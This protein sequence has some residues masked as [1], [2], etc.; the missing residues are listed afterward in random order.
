[1]AI[2]VNRVLHHTSAPRAPWDAHELPTIPLRG[3]ALI[4]IEF[5]T[6]HPLG[7]CVITSPVPHI[8]LLAFLFPSTQ[9]HV[10]ETP[11]HDAGSA[12]NV[13]RVA[14]PFSPGDAPADPFALLFTSETDE[15]QLIT[16]IRTNPAA[17]LFSFNSLPSHHLQGSLLLP[18]HAPLGSTALFLHYDAWAQGH[19][20]GATPT[21][22]ATHVC[23]YAPLTLGEELTFFHL[24][25][26]ATGWYDKAAETFILS[27]ALRR[28]TDAEGAYSDDTVIATV[29]EFLQLML[30]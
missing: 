22:A 24:E 17:A 19:E 25:T 12:H 3:R 23:T 8:G 1:M 13:R 20:P 21:P 2:P 10:Y 15:R 30:P 18:I 28:K 14:A 29:A 26:A 5:V 6:L 11:L 16:C 4:D 9:F 7:E 27:E